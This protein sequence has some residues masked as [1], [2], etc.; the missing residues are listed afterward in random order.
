MRLASVSKQFTAAGILTLVENGQVD[1]DAKISNY[2]P[3]C[4]YSAT[5]RS[6]LNHTSGIP[7]TYMKMPKNEVVTNATVEDWVCSKGS[8]LKKSEQ[9]KYS[10][11]GYVLLARIIERVSGESFEAYMKSAVFDPLGMKKTRVFN[12]LSADDFPE[13]A[14]GFDA[15][16]TN[17][18]PVSLSHLDG[19]AGDGGVFS[20]LT[21]LENWARFWTD[22]R[23]ISAGLKSQAM[24]GAKNDYGFGLICEGDVIWHNGAWLA[25][26]SYF[27]LNTRNDNLIAIIDNGSHFM[28]GKIA[29]NMRRLIEQ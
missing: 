29:Q 3:D 15:S 27:Y 18:K 6:L 24:K 14:V 7:D 26:N 25:T 23:L 1:L 8:T 10:N 4:Q 17:I 22:E 28:L 21:D 16:A 5:V 13:R 19:V 12:R 2:L 11:T 20:S 9:F